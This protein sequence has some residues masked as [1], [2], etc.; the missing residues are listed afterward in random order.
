MVC[1]FP[2][3]LQEIEVGLVMKVNPLCHGC[4]RYEKQEQRPAS[5]RPRDDTE[6]KV[7]VEI[8]GPLSP[9]W[10]LLTGIR[11]RAPSGSLSARAISCTLPWLL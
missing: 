3:T 5:D 11:Q 6:Q 7:G 4:A 9:N 10:L 2:G 8:K 1:T